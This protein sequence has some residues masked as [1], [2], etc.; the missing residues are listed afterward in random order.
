MPNYSLIAVLVAIL[1]FLLWIAY[2]YFSV[3]SIEEPAYTVRDIR[4]GYEVRV[5][6]PHI[7]AE[8][9]VSGTY[10]EALTQ[11]F[12]QIADYIFGNNTARSA[13]AM[14]A[15]VGEQASTSQAIA[16]T[17]PVGESE[18]NGEHVISFVMPS[19]YTLETIP[20]PNNKKV[21]LRLVPAHAVA[22][23]RYSGSTSAAVV[24]KKKELLLSILKRDGV[25][26]TGIPQSA[27]YNP[28][29]TPPFMRR[30]EVLVDIK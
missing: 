11:G 24:A 28:P 30:N 29:W 27:F 1:L 7:V 18:S 23:L 5:Y 8:V 9:H 2:G 26:A 19:T 12:R 10:D 13:I 4:D 6:A 15:P 22:A 17:V 25:T 20:L 3:R 14:T 21:A 16:M